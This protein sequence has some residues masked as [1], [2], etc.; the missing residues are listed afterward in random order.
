MLKKSGHR[1]SSKTDPNVDKVTEIS[2]NDCS[3]TVC[4]IAKELNVNRNREFVF[5]QS[6]NKENKQTEKKN[7]VTS[8]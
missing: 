2:R 8:K 7:S 4:K 6:L 3:L 1:T 5:D